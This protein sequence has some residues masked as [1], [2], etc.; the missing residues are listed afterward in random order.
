MVKFIKPGKVVIVLRG[1]FAGRKAVVIK[2][3][4]EGNKT[5]KFPHAIIAGIK[6]Y[7]LHVRKSMGSRK[8]LRRT[9]VTPFVQVINLQHMMP[10]RYGFD[11]DMTKVFSPE[12][13]EKKQ[14]NTKV[15][16]SLKKIFQDRFRSGQNKWF[17]SKL[18]F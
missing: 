12:V 5:I 4:E 7:P 9:Q 11:A 17:F 18:K 8:I 16:Q 10:T 6:R 1:R 15:T 13:I 2:A 14:F 3:N